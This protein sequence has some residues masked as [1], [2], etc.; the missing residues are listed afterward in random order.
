MESSFQERAYL[1]ARAHY[2]EAL[3]HTSTKLQNEY[4]H[5]GLD[6]IHLATQRGMKLCL[7]AENLGQRIWNGFL[8]YDKAEQILIKQFSD[9]QPDLCQLALR[10]AYSDTR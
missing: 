9:L 5:A 8:S 4:Q 3:L 1:L 6:D 10:K 2:K 7:E